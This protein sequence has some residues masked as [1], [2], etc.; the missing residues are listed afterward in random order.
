MLD[1]I[2]QIREPRKNTANPASRAGLR[3][4]IS[5]NLPHVGADAAVARRYDDPTH[6]YPAEEEKC[7]VI[8]G[9]AVVLI[10]WSGMSS[11]FLFESLLR[12]IYYCVQCG[13]KY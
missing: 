12:G 10:V 1:E 3:P 11:I 13:K 5:P 8:V 7:W 6:V 4:H 2:P 9:R